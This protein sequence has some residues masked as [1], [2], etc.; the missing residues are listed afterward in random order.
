[1]KQFL[2]STIAAL[3]L[4]TGV[5]M[6]Q[7]GPINV[8]TVDPRENA[9]LV[10]TT[11]TETGQPTDMAPR[12][13][14]MSNGLNPVTT[15]MSGYGVGNISQPTVSPKPTPASNETRAKEETGQTHKEKHSATKK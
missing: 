4:L 6:A 9:D 15:N 12:S 2:L 11:G 3:A 14:N 13:Y 7:S 10:N 5:A 8:V 1:M